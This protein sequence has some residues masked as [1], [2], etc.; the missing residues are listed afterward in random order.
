MDLTRTPPRITLQKNGTDT[1]KSA[2]K[3]YIYN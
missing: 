1:Y 3:E 2:C